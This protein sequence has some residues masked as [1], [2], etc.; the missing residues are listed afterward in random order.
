VD[1]ETGIVLYPIPVAYDARIL[2]VRSVQMH[3]RTLNPRSYIVDISDT[4]SPTCALHS[5]P[6]QDFVGALSFET[7]LA[8]L[9]PCENFSDGF[10]ERYRMT[11]KY[12]VLA[13]M[14][15]EEGKPYSRQQEAAQNHVR[16]QRGIHE[17]NVNRLTQDGA[18][19]LTALPQ[20]YII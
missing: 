17:C 3:G 2:C 20:V 15:A 8:P 13:S 16:W 1:I 6:A 7:A 19:D 14:Q 10:L 11:L 12:G 4:D 9:F 18:H 5:V